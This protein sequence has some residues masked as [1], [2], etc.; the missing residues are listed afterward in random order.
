[1]DGRYDWSAI[2]RLTIF[3]PSKSQLITYI[4]NLP[5]AV[6]NSA[7]RILYAREPIDFSVNNGEQLSWYMKSTRLDIWWLYWLESSAPRAFLVLPPVLVLLIA[8]SF[9]KLR[10]FFKNQDSAL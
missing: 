6:F 8:I 4:E 2:R 5:H 7:D 3:V 1:L 10:I 9:L